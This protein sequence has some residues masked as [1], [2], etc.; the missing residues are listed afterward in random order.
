[1]NTKIISLFTDDTEKPLCKHISKERTSLCQP[2]Y[3]EPPF[4]L[5][6]NSQL[7]SNR[8][9]SVSDHGCCSNILKPRG[10]F[11]SPNK[12]R[13]GIIWHIVGTQLAECSLSVGKNLTNFVKL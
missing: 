11:N 3:L 13:F 7:E 9:S 2:R 12:G 6:K 10:N 1:M 8:K 4:H 5:L